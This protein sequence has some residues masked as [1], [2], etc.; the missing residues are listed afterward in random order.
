MEGCT[1][2]GSTSSIRDSNPALSMGSAM[3][4]LHH[5]REPCGRFVRPERDRAST[6]EDLAFG[7]QGAHPIQLAL[8]AGLASQGGDEPLA[9][10]LPVQG[11]SDRPRAVGAA[12][13][14]AD[15][16]GLGVGHDAHLGPLKPALRGLA[17]PLAVPVYDVDGEGQAL[18]EG[19]DAH[20]LRE[21]D[22]VV[23]L[24]AAGE[25]DRLDEAAQEPGRV[26][27][28]GVEAD[29]GQPVDEEGLAAVELVPVV[30]ATWRGGSE[31]EPGCRRRRSASGGGEGLVEVAIDECLLAH[32]VIAFLARPRCGGGS[33]SRGHRPRVGAVAQRPSRGAWWSLSGSID[34]NCPVGVRQSTE[35]TLGAREPLRSLGDFAQTIEAVIDLGMRDTVALRD[36]NGAKAC[37]LQEVPLVDD[38]AVLRDGGLSSAPEAAKHFVPQGQEPVR[39]RDG[40]VAA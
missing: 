31:D 6:R 9:L 36:R 3:G 40:S 26:A 20:P 14:D 24:Q 4:H 32:G 22:R 25:D 29:P 10:P 1:S 23:H 30:G 15:L 11:C 21:G 34:T 28:L 7:S 17:D 2:A 5:G 33:S 16:A 13:H 37:T 19:A 8:A 12:V 18:E 27:G 35:L 39:P 38:W